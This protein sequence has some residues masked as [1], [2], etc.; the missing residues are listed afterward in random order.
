PERIVTRAPGYLVRLDPDELDLL[1]FERLVDDAEHAR[2]ERGARLLREALELWRGRPLAELADESF[3]AAE[4]G[5][6]EEP[7]LAALERRVDAD[8]ALGR[9]AELV[10]ELERLVALYPLRERLHGQLMLALY[11]SGRQAEALAAY[12][13]A[14]HRLVTTV[15]IEP[16]PPLRQLERA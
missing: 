8:L 5:R 13:D 16:G 14:R 15:G 10:A 9:G 7:R 3:A 11:R 6:L 2:P 12:R 4:I 1:R